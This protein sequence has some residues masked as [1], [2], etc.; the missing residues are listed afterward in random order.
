MKQPPII[1]L[2]VL[3][4]VAGCF[5][6]QLFSLV[7]HPYYPTGGGFRY[8]L[9]F[10]SILTAAWFL[11]L[12]QRHAVIRYLVAS[13]I[14]VVALCGYIVYNSF[15]RWQKLTMLQYTTE[16]MPVL[17]VTIFVAWYFLKDD[18]VRI[19]YLEKEVK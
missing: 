7:C 15:V 11:I 18:K 3:L 12:I 4:V 6:W 14:P 10:S 5:L 16:Y 8:P 1:I 2:S 9:L 19:Y 17:I 13:T